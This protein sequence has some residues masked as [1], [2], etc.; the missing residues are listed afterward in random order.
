MKWLSE[1]LYFCHSN[2]ESSSIDID[3]R[4]DCLNKP[5]ISNMPNTINKRLQVPNVSFAIKCIV[6]RSEH[7]HLICRLFLLSAEKLWKRHFLCILARRQTLRTLH[8]YF[9]C[10]LDPLNP[11]MQNYSMIDDA[12]P[13]KGV[14]INYL[15]F[16]D[17]TNQIYRSVTLNIFC[18]TVFATDNNCKRIN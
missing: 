8:K 18:P 3:H 2:E 9:F 13:K 17:S 10:Y 6:D 7:P 15:P 14:K 4:I 16:Y 11:M 12:A 1:I 5:C